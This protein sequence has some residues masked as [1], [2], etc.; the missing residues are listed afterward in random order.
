MI[1]AYGAARFLSQFFAQIRD[2]VFAKVGVRA[3]RRASGAVLAHLHRLSLRF[4]LDRRTGGLTRSIERG[5]NAIDSLLSISLFN[6]FPTVLEVALVF[7]I[8]WHAFNIWFG[9]RSRWSTSLIYGIAFY[10]SS[11][12]NG[13]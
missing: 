11:R 4:H 8:L 2:A 9:V 10:R 7:G 3:V 12:P 13:G 5:R 6:V 1:L